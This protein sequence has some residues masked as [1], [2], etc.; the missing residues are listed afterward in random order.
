[1]QRYQ[2]ECLRTKKDGW[3]SLGIAYSSDQDA[4]NWVKA[5]RVKYPKQ[6]F[7]I[8]DTKLDMILCV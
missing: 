8:R 6:A 3:F 4:I 2:I 5:N 1:M 7:R